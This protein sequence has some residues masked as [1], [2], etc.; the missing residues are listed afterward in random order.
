VMVTDTGNKRVQ[1]FDSQGKFISLFGGDG[2]APGN[3]REPVGIAVDRSGNIYVADTWNR[4]IQKFDSQQR[5]VAQFAVSGWDS[6]SIVNKPYLAVDQDGRIY[7]TEPEKNRFV[8]LGPTGQQEGAKGVEGSDP[9]SLSLPV[10]ID[11]SPQGEDINERDIVLTEGKVLRPQDLAIIASAGY[12][13]VNV[14]KKPK[15]GVITTGNELVMPRP[16][17][18]GAEVINSNHYTFKA[19][20]EA[21]M[22]IPTLVHC[23]DSHKLVEEEFERLL[24]THDAL[25][26][27]GGTAISKGD[28][29]VDAVQSNHEGV[30]V[31]TIQSAAEQGYQFIILNAAAFTHY[32][33]A[34]RD[35]IAGVT[36][37]VIEVHLSNIHKREEFRHHSVIAPVVMGQICGFGADSYLAALNIVLRKLK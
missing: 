31:D 17:I 36:V 13:R 3:L 25:I 28:V 15:I 35:A 4:R 18:R 32:S 34:L 30:L 37:P 16:D 11:V 24:D 26:S 10:G 7:Y 19:I 33:I 1:L 6:Q 8:V 22:A 12:N 21:S 23:F 5:P 2:T 20:V 27:T 9:A 14:F 29:V